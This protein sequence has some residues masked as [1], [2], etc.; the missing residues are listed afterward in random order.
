MNNNPA[1]VIWSRLIGVLFVAISSLIWSG[2]V[3]QQQIADR[4]Q[5]DLEKTEAALS[6][7]YGCID[8]IPAPPATAFPLK[9][10][11]QEIGLNFAH[12]VGP[13]GSYYV[14]E[15]VGS[16]AAWADFDSDG[17]L[18]LLLVN[19]EKS[20]KA[21]SEF[22]EEMNTDWCVYRGTNEGLADMTETAQLSGL[23]FGMG[24]SV[25]DLDN[26]GDPDVYVTCVKQDRILLNEGGFHFRDIAVP[27]G[28]QESEWGTGVSLF[29]FD[30]N[31]WLDIVV[32]NYTHD[33]IYDHQVACGFRKGLISY[34][35]PHKFSPTVDRLYR[36]DG[37]RRIEGQENAIPHF[38]EVT[39]EAGMSES[40]S[41]GFT[42]VTA[43]FT[44]D[45]WPDMLIANDSQPNRFW[46]NQ[47]DGTFL[48]QAVQHGI[49]LNGAGAAQGNMGIAVGDIDRNSTLDAVISELSTESTTL[50]QNAGNGLFYD[51]TLSV[52]LQRPTL[53]HTGWGAALI[54]LDHDGWLDLPLV[55]GLV[56]PCHSRFAPH[57]EDLFQAR[58]VAVRDNEQ[59]W[60][61]YAD[62]NLL[63]MSTGKPI[64]RDGTN[65][66]GGDFT[67]SDGSGRC[68]LYGDPDEDGDLDLLVTNC[69]QRARYYRNDF[70]KQGH[71]TR[72]RLLTCEG[73]RDAIG[74][75]VT[76]HCGDDRWTSVVAPCTSFLASHDPRVHFGLGEKTHVDRVIVRWPD[77]PVDQCEEEFHGAP[78]DEDRI[79]IRGSGKTVKEAP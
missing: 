78:A 49:A 58:V 22:P 11:T 12:T 19:G 33:E 62:R 5:A 35:G 65:D 48:E 74:A 47:R 73:G 18:D 55:N 10:V 15:S 60:H 61:D 16:G 54:D 50:Y 34:C 46:V 70:L 31:G 67:R 14:P 44:G 42:V 79:L 69:G 17:R 27:A 6:S 39:D 37:L 1:T 53:A 72:F 13:P 2:H 75:K 68:L 40:T 23:G 41:Y 51:N 45:D 7:G 66:Q 71:W 38:T 56:I 77:G 4:R 57:G 64:L 52:G 30:R 76:V 25:G 3:L 29:D 9:D 59:Y 24:C 32:A 20:P 28:I 8:D 36:N 43:D 21:P 63:L 26:D